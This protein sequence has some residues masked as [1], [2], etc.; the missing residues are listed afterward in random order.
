MSYYITELY[1]TISCTYVMTIALLHNQT[2]MQNPV[3]LHKIRLAMNICTFESIK[4]SPR[5]TSINYQIYIKA[6]STKL[7]NKVFNC[8]IT[9]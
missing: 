1:V 8:N 7:T 3:K 9:L 4:Q 5:K 6:K 2:N